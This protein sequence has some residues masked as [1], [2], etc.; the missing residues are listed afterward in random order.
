MKCDFEPTVSSISD[1]STIIR[2]VEMAITT[3]KMKSIMYPYMPE[4]GMIE[5]N[6]LKIHQASH[7]AIM[8][9]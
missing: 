8:I 3:K 1:A 7:A 4:E 5:E 6:E 9:L 2:H